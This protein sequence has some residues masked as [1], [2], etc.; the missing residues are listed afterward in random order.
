[1]IQFD[2]AQTPLSVAPRATAK[3]ATGTI[4][5]ASPVA[6]SPYLLEWRDFADWL[7]HGRPPRVRG[8]DAVEA[9]RIAEAALESNK[10][11]QPVS[12]N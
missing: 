11:G 12:L 3:G 4:V 6:E 5:P 7:T 2:S 9:V 1:M 10:T 8:E